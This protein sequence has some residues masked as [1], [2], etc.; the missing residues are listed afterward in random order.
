MIS[1]TWRSPSPYTK[2]SRRTQSPKP[3]SR[4]N[5]F[6]FASAATLEAGYGWEGDAELGESPS[7]AGRFN[8]GGYTLLVLAKMNLLTPA[9]RA[10]TANR[11]VPARFTSRA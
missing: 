11:A 6:N 8:P 1:Q 5:S 3:S 4:S 7:R 9:F 2:P 10:A